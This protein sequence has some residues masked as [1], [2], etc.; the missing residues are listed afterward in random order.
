[1]ESS[2]S[3]VLRA[4][5]PVFPS[6]DRRK[7]LAAVS[8]VLGDCAFAVEDGDNVLVKSTD[9]ACLR[10]VKEQL[11]DRHVRDAA[12][13]LM[14]RLREGD[15]LKLLLNKQAAFAGVVAMCTTQ[16]EPPLGAIRV[17]IDCDR[18][19]ELVDWLTAH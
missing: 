8:N 5:A 9:P 3:I 18:P 6:E 13:R 1:M 10:K 16:T 4:Y 17:E 2:F 11:R 14:L 7:V 12:K 19:V 15:R